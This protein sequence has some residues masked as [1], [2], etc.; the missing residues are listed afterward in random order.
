MVQL[1]DVAMVVAMCCIAEHFVP[2]LLPCRNR[3]VIQRNLYLHNAYT[4]KCSNNRLMV[5]VL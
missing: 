4:D 3:D 2:T 5:Q 1:T